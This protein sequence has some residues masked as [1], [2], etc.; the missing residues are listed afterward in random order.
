[1]AVDLVNQFRQRHVSEP[2][3]FLEAIPERLF[4]ADA[5]L[6]T[7]YG[8]VKR[9]LKLLM[10][11]SL[12]FHGVAVNAFSLSHSAGVGRCARFRRIGLRQRG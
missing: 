8:R 12:E 4:K 6:A 5:G 2:G 11:R 10:A 1:M 7:R 3:D 9:G